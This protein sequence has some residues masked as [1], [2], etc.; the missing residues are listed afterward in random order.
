[1]TQGFVGL[2]AKR[3]Q[4]LEEE[5]TAVKNK[6]TTTTT[7]NQELGYNSVAGHLP[8][9]NKELGSTLSTSNKQT[10]TTVALKSALGGINASLPPHS[11]QLLQVA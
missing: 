10:T 1:V 7:N 8:N 9:M 4:G 11:T 6:T 2:W 5:S 3:K